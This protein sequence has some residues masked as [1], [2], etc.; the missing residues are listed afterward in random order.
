M[1]DTNSVAYEMTALADRAMSV[2]LTPFQRDTYKKRLQLSDSG[3]DYFL[4]LPES[5]QEAIWVSTMKIP[6]PA[7]RQRGPRPPLEVRGEGEGRH[8][9]M[10]S[11]IAAMWDGA[12]DED[13]FVEK[14]MEVNERYCSPPK[15][16][17]KIRNQVQWVMR[18]EPARGPAVIIGAPKK[19][20]LPEWAEVPGGSFRF[21]LGPW[22]GEKHGIFG[23]RRLHIISG[24][25]GAGKSTLALQ[26]LE[27]QAKGEP[28]FDRVS[29]GWPYL[30]VW[31]D[32]GKADLE[33]QL[34]NMGLLQT[35]PPYALVNPE[36][37]AMGPAQAV[38]EIYLN[39][40]SE[41]E[42]KP[43]AIFVEGVDMWSDDSTDM[44][45]VGTLCSE[46]LKVAEHYDLAII[47]SAGSPKRKVKEGYLAVRDRVI[48]S[49]AWGRKTSTLVEV[50]EEQN[51][52]HRRIVT[53]L[54]RTARAQVLTMT[55]RNGRLEP[56]ALE[57]NITAGKGDMGSK[58]EVIFSYLDAKPGLTPEGLSRAF[59]PMGDSTARRW[60]S[61]HRK[62]RSVL[63]Q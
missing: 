40:N 35:P 51:E 11:A 15:P 1:M 56:A 39:S 58:R 3:V 48:G 57:V 16:E 42:G 36:Q 63:A 7:I 20:I 22:D 9:M 61:E 24:A 21:M 18:K 34:D 43:K 12:M 50:V 28:F 5:E 17:S 53:V 6:E 49:S 62:E 38:E 23:T 26:M 33:E 37:V 31:Q 60:I 10:M 13:T 45:K 30:I 29:R 25:S 41:P 4:T 19:L 52:E 54:S 55:M 47:F 32:R 8:P 14:A 27:A 44:K 46:L 2:T 59:A